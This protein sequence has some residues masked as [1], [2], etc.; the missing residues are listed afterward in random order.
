MR[1][2]N[3]LI[4]TAVLFLTTE[5]PP[6]TAIHSRP[7]GQLSAGGIP[8]GGQLD[9]WIEMGDRR[10]H[11]PCMIDEPTLRRVGKIEP[12]RHDPWISD[13]SRPGA[14]DRATLGHLNYLVNTQAKPNGMLWS[15]QRYGISLLLLMIAAGVVYLVFNAVRADSQKASLPMEIVRLRYA[16]GEITGDDYSIMKRELEWR[17][18]RRRGNVRTVFLKLEPTRSENIPRISPTH[19]DTVP[20]GTALRLTGRDTDK[21][22]PEP[23]RSR[24][25]WNEGRSENMLMGADRVGN[26]LVKR[27]PDT[28]RE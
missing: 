6:G 17:G 13:H 3:L 15:A 23:R 22:G 11:M 9:E 19:Q 20:H 28:F 5:V 26:G 16:W 7:A 8:D 18:G 2:C 14:A 10:I 24:L 21:I 4:W 12:S 27:F 1:E 25:R